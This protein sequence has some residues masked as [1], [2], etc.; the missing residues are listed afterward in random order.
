MLIMFPT[1][2]VDYVSYGMRQASNA[3]SDKRKY[4]IGDT[5]V[6]DK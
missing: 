2:F 6:G 4:K 1:I 3:A 5:E